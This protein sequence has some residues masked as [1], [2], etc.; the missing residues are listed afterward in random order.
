MLFFQ[1]FVSLF[2]TYSAAK[3]TSRLLAMSDDQLSV[4]G[5]DRERLV[6]SYIQ[7]LGAR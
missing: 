7:G 3:R 5:M 6:R 4:L 1:G 2:D